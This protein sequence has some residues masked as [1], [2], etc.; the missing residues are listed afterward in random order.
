M[1]DSTF[2]AL[3]DEAVKSRIF[4][5]FKG[6]MGFSDP[7]TD[8]SIWPKAIALRK[9]AEKLGADKVEFFNIWRSSTSYSF[10]RANT[11][12]AL[13]GLDVP[14]MVD[15]GTKNYKFVPRDLKYSIWF[16]SQYKDR[17]NKIEESFIFWD[18]RNPK[19]DLILDEYYPLPM[20]IMTGETIYEVSNEELFNKGNF[21]VLRLDLTL[22]AF[23]LDPDDVDQRSS[24]TITSISLNIEESSKSPNYVT[25]FSGIVEEGSQVGL[26]EGVEGAESVIKTSI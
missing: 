21:H 14:N 12:L 15:S 26:F 17:L 6:A 18:Y 8:G 5:K 1:T 4:Y 24:P 3:I 25:L 23:I 13:K 10:K 16:W 19:L 7:D 20:D 2:L 11:V 22:E 9:R